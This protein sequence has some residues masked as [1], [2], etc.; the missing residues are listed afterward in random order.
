MGDAAQGGTPLRRTMRWAAV[1]TL[2]HYSGSV[3]IQYRGS[4]ASLPG[5]T[6][7]RS[8]HV[9]VKLQLYGC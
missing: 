4:G 8:S 2:A 9:F 1:L 5:R 3:H 6:L 7:N